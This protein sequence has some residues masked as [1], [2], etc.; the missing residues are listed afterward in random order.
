MKKIAYNLTF[1]SVLML[2]ASACS[3]L[4]EDPRTWEKTTIKKSTSKSNAPKDPKTN[5]DWSGGTGHD[6]G[7]S[8]DGTESGTNQ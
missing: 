1:L 6:W 5:L 8:G 2:G 7:D 3:T 4:P